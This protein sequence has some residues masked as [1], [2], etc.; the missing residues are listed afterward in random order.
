MGFRDQSQAIKLEHKHLYLLSHLHGPNRWFLNGAAKA[1]LA[2]STDMP[3]TLTSRLSLP[4]ASRSMMSKMSSWIFSP[5]TDMEKGETEHGTR[6]DL[7]VAT[8]D[9]Y[10]D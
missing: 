1:P 10:M 7:R 5:W 9:S 2:S 8:I 6:T 4:S 3:G